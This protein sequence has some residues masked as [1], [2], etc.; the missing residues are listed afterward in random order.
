MKTGFCAKGFASVGKFLSEMIEKTKHEDISSAEALDVWKILNLVK[1]NRIKD[2][3]CAE[4]LKLWYE[5]V[6]A[7]LKKGKSGGSRFF[8]LL[9]VGSS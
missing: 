2:P 5:N 4:M 8:P 7:L 9:A 3:R 1:E 6:L